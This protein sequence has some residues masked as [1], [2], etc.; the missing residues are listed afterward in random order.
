MTYGVNRESIL[1]SLL[2]FDVANE[3]VVPDLMYDILEG[4]YYIRLN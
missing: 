3:C 1:N 4:I 2:Y